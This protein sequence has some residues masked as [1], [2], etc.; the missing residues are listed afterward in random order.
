MLAI[1]VS[2]S[3]RSSRCQNESLLL[4]HQDQF[5]YYGHL[6]PV[7]FHDWPYHQF[8]HFHTNV[9]RLI[10]PVLIGYVGGQLKP[11][12]WASKASQ[13]LNGSSIKFDCE[14]CLLVAP[15]EKFVILA[16]FQYKVSALACIPLLW[17]SLRGV[18]NFAMINQGGEV[19]NYGK[20][21]RNAGKERGR[22]GL[23]NP[24]WSAMFGCVG[25]GIHVLLMNCP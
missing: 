10:R 14:D 15:S 9:H 8:G 17:D 3:F 16:P 12:K 23:T 13:V 20:R 18:A 2:T 24:S 7:W 5:L 11:F 22:Y 19:C 25:H 1:L 21:R 4:P 6:L